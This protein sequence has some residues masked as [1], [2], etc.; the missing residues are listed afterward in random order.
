MI[1]GVVIVTFNRPQLLERAIKSIISQDY[2]NWLTVIINNGDSI[3][4]FSDKRI[5]QV[6]AEDNLGSNKA[7]NLALD[8][9]I[10]KKVNYLTII[11]DD[12]Y[13][14]QGSFSEANNMI[15]ETN[16]SWLISNC[17]TPNEKLEESKKPILKIQEFDYI[18]DYLY[19]NNFS[20]D[21][22]HMIKTSLIQNIRFDK[23]IFNGEEWLFF[24]KLA[25][26]SKILAYPHVSLR[27]DYQD[28]GLTKRIKTRKKT[29][30][31]LIIETKKP[32]LS[33]LIRPTNLKA[34]RK[35]ISR[36]FELPFKIIKL[37]FS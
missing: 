26:K 30:Q 17:L 24:I 12:D 4:E 28:G 11:D 31:K 32:I 29:F 9:L 37:S 3:Q 2:E 10:D 18:D 15:L 1:F 36:I 6:Q 25:K 5:I 13:L 33:F 14:E 21:K 7:R 34:F 20:G 22:F 27:K 35:A 23:K 8:I 16:K 19:G